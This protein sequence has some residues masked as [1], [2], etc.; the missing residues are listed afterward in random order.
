M[1]ERTCPPLCSDT[2]SEGPV[3]LHATCKTTGNNNQTTLNSC[4]AH[5]STC[6]GHTSTCC[7]KNKICCGDDHGGR[8][9]R[10]V[11]HRS[12]TRHDRETMEMPWQYHT[13]N[14][15]NALSRQHHTVL[16][17]PQCHRPQTGTE[18][19]Q[20][21]KREYS[22]S[23]KCVFDNP[24]EPLQLTLHANLRNRVS[25]DCATV[26]TEIEE[27]IVELLLS[28]CPLCV[29]GRRAEAGPHSPNCA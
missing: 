27:S 19:Q 9:T 4:R 15:E 23:P 28:P 17:T 10:P 22:R 11:N 26:K 5:T 7:D 25:H 20:R 2:G 24:R 13:K 16:P 3:T 8:N 1:L 6:R 12:N 14:W 29:R 21:R 18:H